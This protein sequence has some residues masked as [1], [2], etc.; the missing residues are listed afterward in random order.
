[1]VSTVRFNYY[2][3]TLFYMVCFH[4]YRCC[5]V[6]FLCALISDLFVIL[7]LLPRLVRACDFISERFWANWF[8]IQKTGKMNYL[9]AM[10]CKANSIFSRHFF[11]GGKYVN[12]T[13]WLRIVRACNKT[14]SFFF[15]LSILCTIWENRHIIQNNG[16]MY[17]FIYG[18]LINRF[19]HN[20]DNRR[21]I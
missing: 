18:A 11:T 7:N 16:E 17:R 20:K 5:L 1:M 3:C 6:C 10:N 4:C 15:L 21:F 12:K 19:F 13:D 14:V 2:N 8:W 9:V